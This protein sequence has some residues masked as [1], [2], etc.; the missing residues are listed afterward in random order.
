MQIPPLSF[1]IASAFVAAAAIGTA[2]RL[3][4]ASRQIAAVTAHRGEVPPSFASRISLAEHQKAADYTV[5]TIRFGRLSVVVDAAVTL[6][7]TVGGVIGLLDVLS[8][9]TDWSALWRGALVI[10]AVTVLSSLIGP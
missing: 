10:L 1:A 5:A 8:S 6:A 7:L 2:L 3:W 9:G 4:L